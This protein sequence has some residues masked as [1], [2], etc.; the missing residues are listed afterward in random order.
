M[1]LS[2]ERN[3]PHESFPPVISI[4]DAV[5][6]DIHF[7]E[8]PVD[9]V[10]GDYTVLYQSEEAKTRNKKTTRSIAVYLD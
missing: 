5:T 3:V 4:F 7:E 6:G 10:T 9:L 1:F 2:S 8:N